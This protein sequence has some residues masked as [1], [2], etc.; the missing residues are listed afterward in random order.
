MEFCISAEEQFSAIV[1][2]KHESQKLPELGIYQANDSVKKAQT[3][4]MRTGKVHV[5]VDICAVF[6]FDIIPLGMEG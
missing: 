2:H 1:V 5:E 3:R 4:T 6:V